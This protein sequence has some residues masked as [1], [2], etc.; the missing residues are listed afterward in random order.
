MQEI[1]VPQQA[2]FYM[3]ETKNRGKK[4]E[5]LTERMKRSSDERHT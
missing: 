3:K 5:T 4:G 2:K 1:Q